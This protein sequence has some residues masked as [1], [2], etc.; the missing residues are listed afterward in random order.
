MKYFIGIDIG[1]T[2]LKVFALD[3]NN[4]LI[5]KYS[6]KTRTISTQKGFQEQNPAAIFKGVLSILKKIIAHCSPNYQL[7]GVCFSAAMHSLIAF[8]NKGKPLSNAILWSDLRAQ[9][10]VLKFKQN[11]DY[12]SIIL[13]NGT[14]AHP[15]NPFFKIDWLKNNQKE[16]FEKTAYFGSIK[17]YIWQRFFQEIKMDI[18]DASASGLMHLQKLQWSTKAIQYLGIKIDNLPQ[19]CSPYYHQKLPEKWCKILGCAPKTPFVI[20]ASDGALA[21]FGV[22]ELNPQTLVLTIGTSAALRRSTTQGKMSPD[23]ST[24]C[25]RLDENIFIE[26]AASNNGAN[27]LEWLKNT[28]FESREP[29]T[30]FLQK[31][32]KI[33]SGSDGLV[34]LPYI[35]GERAPIWDATAKGSFLGINHQHTKAH[36]IRATMEGILLN[37]KKI[38]DSLPD[39]TNF[40]EI[41]VSGGFTQNEFWLKMAAQILN[42]PLQKLPENSA[43]PSSLGAIK[44]GRIALSKSSNNY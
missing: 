22:G 9:N 36:F 2:N 43:D 10:E 33:P 29:M 4:E 41:A 5:H 26:G 34:F 12:Q 24:F 17:T 7:E 1:T 13:E 28:V 15:M 11:L 27:C 16:I 8:D 20:G 3:E 39:A 25:Y 32:Q 18:S 31:A 42:L 14:P 37:L 23:G 19:L 6:I 40:K 30:K 35:H 44:M 38:V 21:N